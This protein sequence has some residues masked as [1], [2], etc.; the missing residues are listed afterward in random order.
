MLKN[1]TAKQP[2]M[3]KILLMLGI[4]VICALFAL[5]EPVHSTAD[6]FS[7]AGVMK[8]KEK[9]S[10]PGFVITDI[11]GNKVDLK[12]YRGNVVLVMFWTTW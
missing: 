5:L 2:K 11:E 3:K 7:A 9:I 1:D 4:S 6:P 10:A 12:D 8:F